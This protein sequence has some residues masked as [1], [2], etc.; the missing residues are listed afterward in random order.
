[1]TPHRKGSLSSG[2]RQW[3]RP[4]EGE[5]IRRGRGRD[6]GGG[7]SVATSVDVARRAGV[8]QSAV[9]LV[10]GGKARGRVGRQT[11][12][13]ILR[14]ARQLAYR[15]N[16]AARALRSGQS[17]LLVL[18]VPDVSNP[19]FA[20]VFEG[21]E[22]EARKHDYSVMLT[23]IQDGHHCLRLVRDSLSARSVDGFLLFNTPGFDGRNDLR[24]RAVL[25][26]ASSRDLTCLRLDVEAGMRA[27]VAHLV[28]LQHTKIAHLAA[29]VDVETFRLR[30][31]AYL[32]ALR[33][34]AL[35]GPP[36]YQVSAAFATADA[37][38]G[39]RTLLQSA[40]PPTAIVCDSDVLA[41]G[42]YKAAKELQRRIPHDVSV[43]GFDDGII[44]QML[45]PELTTVAIPT[46]LIGEQGVRLLLGVLAGAAV[47]SQK[48]VPLELVVRGSTT[49]VK[50]AL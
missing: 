20:S 49:T 36:A 22:R 19:Y 17:R 25:V 8:S 12:R 34:A 7:G 31:T 45:D 15:P 3:A 32:A 50:A 11:Q 26:D 23:G 28:Q 41:V 13:T 39:A 46:A 21:A 5:G 48:M 9:S 47:P 6:S 38:L 2:A 42:V 35:G 44:A 18:A 10:L 33:E 24:G 29:A 30:K 27:A 40:D 4:P 16:T 43:V 37:I 14:A 1:M